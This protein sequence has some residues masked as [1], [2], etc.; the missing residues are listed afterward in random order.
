M[1]YQVFQHVDINL[2]RNNTITRFNNLRKR[3]G[4]CVYTTA[5]VCKQDYTTEWITTKLGGRILYW[6][7]KYPLNT[8]EGSRDLFS[9]QNCP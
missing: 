3:E 4:L 5:M 1:E 2:N 6:L 9:Y 8:S 7:G